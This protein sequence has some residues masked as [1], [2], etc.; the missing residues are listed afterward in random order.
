MR[1]HHIGYLIK[2]IERAQMAFERLGFAVSQNT[3]YDEFRDVDILFMKKDGYIVELVSPRSTNSVVAKLIKT[4]RNTPYHI[5]FGSEDLLRDIRRLT[6]A[7]FTEIDRPAPAP[8]LGGRRVCFLMSPQIGMIEL[9]EE[10][11]QNFET[12]GAPRLMLIWNIN[13]KRFGICTL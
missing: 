7:G 2:R 9:L 6:E 4:Y 3:V 11:P 12:G 10:G 13:I 8:A 5:C 1:I